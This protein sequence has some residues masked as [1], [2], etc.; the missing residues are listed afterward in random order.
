MPRQPKNRKILTFFFISFELFPAPSYILGALY[1]LQH[2]FNPF[3]A[4]FTTIFNHNFAGKFL[5][6]QSFYNFQRIFLLFFFSYLR[7]TIKFS[8]LIILFTLS[9]VLNCQR[10]TNSRQNALKSSK[11]QFICVGNGKKCFNFFYIFFFDKIFLLFCV[12]RCG[13]SLWIGIDA[14][15]QRSWYEKVFEIFEGKK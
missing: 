9:I 10:F 6:F 11:C 8:F 3:C 4:L 7:P 14:H 15:A 5:Q 2:L 12:L 13:A 1:P